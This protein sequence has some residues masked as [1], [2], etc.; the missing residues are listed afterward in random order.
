M[1]VP[2]ALRDPK[3]RRYRLRRHRLHCAGGELSVVAPA[4][5]DDLLEGDGA[6]EFLRRGQIPYWAD[7]WPASVGM[8]RQLMKGPDLAGRRVMDLG[9]GIGIAGLAAATRG[10]HVHFVDL[11][12]DALRFARFNARKLPSERLSFEQLDWFEA[13]VAQCFDLVLL[14]DVAYEE[15]N[16]EPLERHLRS[17]LSDQ[18]QCMVGDPYRAATDGFLAS[19]EPD[20]TV[21]TSTVHTSFR[22]DK[23]ELRLATI[24]RAP[25]APNGSKA[26]TT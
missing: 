9:C 16:F 18:G 1:T 3:L 8:A 15:R 24:R 14:A 2:E 4:R 19:L 5:G 11:E 20:F 12:P 10:A 7:V 6:V 13:T 17:C 22:D 23:I 25:T 21:S 26:S